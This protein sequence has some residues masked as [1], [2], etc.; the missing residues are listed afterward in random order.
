MPDV[1]DLCMGR[2]QCRLDVTQQ[3]IDTQACQGFTDYMF[4]DFNCVK[5]TKN[6]SAIS[7]IQSDS[8]CFCS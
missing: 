4:I 2:P 1:R 3:Y 8:R 7:L 6:N 5:G